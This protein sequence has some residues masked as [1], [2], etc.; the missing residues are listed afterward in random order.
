MPPL[1][2]PMKTAELEV[3]LRGRVDGTYP[4]AM[5]YCAAESDADKVLAT[6]RDREARRG[7]LAHRR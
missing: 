2:T 6:R 3:H 1:S 4:V 5:R 7:H